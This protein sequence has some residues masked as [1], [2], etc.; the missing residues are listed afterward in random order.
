MDSCFVVECRYVFA[1]AAADDDDD[2]D[3]GHLI[4][5]LSHTLRNLYVCFQ[6][7]SMTQILPFVIFGI[8][9]DDTFV[10]MGAYTS[11]TDATSTEQ[12][13]HQT[14]QDVG[15]SITLTTITSMLAFGLGC[16]SSVPAVYWLCLYA[17]PTIAFVYIYQLTFFV[18]AMVLDERRI[19]QGRRDMC[20]CVTVARENTNNGNNGTTT[21]TSTE[22]KQ[23]NENPTI[24]NQVDAAPEQQ[25][26]AS[27]APTAHFLERFIDWY[28]D[29]LL[30]PAVK[31]TVVVAFAA[32][33]GLCIW[34]ALQLTIEFNV[35]DVMPSDSYASDFLTTQKIVTERAVIDAYVYFR[36]VN[37]SS[38]EVQDQM[39][40]YI[41]DL[42][43]LEEIPR[44][45]DFFWLYDFETFVADEANGVSEVPFVQQLDAFLAREEYALL[46]ANDIARDEE[47]GEI[48]GSRVMVFMDNVDIEDVHDQVDALEAVEDVSESQPVNQGGG[49]YS[50][51]I[52]EAIFQIWGEFV[53][54]VLLVYLANA[55]MCFFAF[56]VRV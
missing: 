3:D 54:P 1:A 14:I 6:F 32:L 2:D 51:F 56:L 34:S 7:T 41:E 43:A 53:G 37:Q 17:I 13:I 46:Y 16:L 38:L 50:F 27:V 5:L 8:G 12:R 10:M 35:V 48:H 44:G 29:F 23:E 24:D 9:L 36:N 33:L 40:T 21:A 31:V 26:D 52:Y 30:Q 49:D 4:F 22:H 42:V 25:V 47:T 45:P 28:A 15:T 11:H 55:H 20:P 39:K 19:A 18:A